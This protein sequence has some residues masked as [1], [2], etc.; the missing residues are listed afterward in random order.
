MKK[1][2]SVIMAAALAFSLSAP[3]AV[4]GAAE[5]SQQ[6]EQ[7]E[8]AYERQDG[9]V[10]VWTDDESLTDEEISLKTEMISEGEY[11]DKAAE[12]LDELAAICHFSYEKDG[13]TVNTNGSYYRIQVSGY[14]NVKKVMWAHFYQIKEDG[15]I[16]PLEAEVVHTAPGTFYQNYA[17]T[18]D[19]PCDILMTGKYRPGDM[20]G[21]GELDISD[22]IAIMKTAIKL[23]APNVSGASNGDINRDGTVDVNDAIRVLKN[24]V[25]LKKDWS[26]GVY[27]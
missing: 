18:V 5:G 19:A 24:V 22:A 23:D 25:G 21:D 16:V 9:E 12:G 15:S 7:D 26:Y 14:W 10:I 6:P 4:F 2:F 17:V 1:W 8:A 3:A 11:L 27:V 13:Q 20:N